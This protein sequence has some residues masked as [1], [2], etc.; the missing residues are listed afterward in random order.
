MPCPAP[1]EPGVT[2]VVPTLI[3]ALLG[4]RKISKCQLPPPHHRPS[5][6]PAQ[7]GANSSAWDA[8]QRISELEFPE[9]FCAKQAVQGLGFFSPTNAPSQGRLADPSPAEGLCQPLHAQRME[10]PLIFCRQTPRVLLGREHR[11]SWDSCRSPA[12]ASRRGPFADR[13]RPR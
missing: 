13:P 12:S 6:N 1:S 3:P 4:R 2:A 10:E 7:H 5:V 9:P 11:R 8:E